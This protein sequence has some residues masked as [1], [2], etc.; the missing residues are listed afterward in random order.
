[1]LPPLSFTRCV[2]LSMA[3]LQ[4]AKSEWILEKFSLLRAI[5]KLKLS[6]LN[7]SFTAIVLTLK[8]SSPQVLKDLLNIVG[9]PSTSSWVPKSSQEIAFRLFHTAY[10]VSASGSNSFSYSRLFHELQDMPLTHGTHPATRDLSRLS[11]Y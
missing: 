4:R 1:M 6:P 5:S 10:L 8:S 2:D 7:E 3:T 11:K 9:E